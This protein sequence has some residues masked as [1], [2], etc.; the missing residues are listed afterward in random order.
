MANI[1]LDVDGV[2]ADF[3]LKCASLYGAAANPARAR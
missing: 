1:F 2:F 3:Q